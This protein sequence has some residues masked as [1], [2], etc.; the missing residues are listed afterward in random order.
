MTLLSNHI[1]TNN[2]CFFQ[3]FFGIVKYEIVIRL[4]NQY[5]IEKN[6]LQGKLF[7]ILIFL[8]L[9]N[10]AFDSFKYLFIIINLHCTKI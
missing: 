2:I 3:T 6:Y 8:K 9:S 5:H 7:N 10:I 1:C 4:L